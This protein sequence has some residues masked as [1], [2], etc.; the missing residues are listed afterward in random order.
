MKHSQCFVWMFV[1]GVANNALVRGNANN[2][3]SS[4][5]CGVYLAESTIPDAG[6]GMFAGNDYAKGDQVTAGDVVIPLIEVE[7]NNDFD[8]DLTFI[9]DAYTWA[10]SDFGGMDDETEDS[11]QVSGAS[12]GI[13][14]AANCM[15]SLIN[16]DSLHPKLDNAGLHRS[17]DAGAGAFTPYHDRVSFAI[18]DISAGQELFISYGNTYFTKRQLNRIAEVETSIKFYNQSVR[19]ITW[20]E[21]H[22]TCMD[23]IR[24]GRSTIPQAGRGA[25]ASRFIPKNSVVAPAPLIHIPDKSILRIFAPREGDEGDDLVRNESKPVHRQLLVNYCFGH[26]NSSL[27]LSPYGSVTSL[28]NHSSK[29]PNARIEWSKGMSHPEWLELSLESLANEP[30]TGLMFNFVALRDIQQGEEIL[31]NYGKEWEDAWNDHVRNW[32]PGS[33]LYMPAYELNNNADLMIRTIHE[34]PYPDNLLLYIHDEY[35]VISGL[36]ESEFKQHQCRVLDRY[37]M[38]GEVVYMVE[39]FFTTD[40]D[41]MTDIEYYDEVLFAVPRDAFVFDDI[42]YSRDHSMH[43]SFRHEM[44]IPDDMF[45]DKW[46]S[47]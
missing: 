15:P 5:S 22:G 47:Q 25:F 31:I 2:D 46:M 26:T 41:D 18:E 4:H 32:M 17:R 33:E 35:R 9:W 8:P 36:E 23:N 44:M 16:V 10:S 45:P 13:G 39:L 21:K 37:G 29:H 11:D 24:P 43:S 40:K 27:L 6:L 14:A 34:A 7:W 38:E 3:R 12:P 20:L 19:D 42:A 1:L 30:R 28:I